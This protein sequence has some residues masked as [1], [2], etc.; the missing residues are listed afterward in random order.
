MQHIA[1]WNG[2][3]WSG[4]AGGVSFLPSPSGDDTPLVLALAEYDDGGGSALY[5]GGDFTAAGGVPAN[6]VAKWNGSSWSAL[7]SG[8]NSTVLS[9]AVYD[10]G[11]GPALYAG[12]RFTTAGGVA[13]SRIAKWD[14]SSW[15]ALGSGTNSDVLALTAHDDGGGP[16]LYAGGHFATAGGAA[17]SAIARW[18]GASWSAVGGGM[19][20]FGWVYSLAE[21]D[22]G[23]G[24]A[25]YAGGGFTTAGGVA[26]NRIAKWDGVS[27]SAL[28]GGVFGDEVNDG[29]YAMATHD[30]GSGPALI[31]AGRFRSAL[32]SGDSYVAKWGCDS[33][34][35]TLSCPSSV[36]VTERFGSPLGEIVNYSVTASDE[37]DPAPG[38]VGVPPSGSLF[39]IGTTLVTC[40]ATDASGN[41]STCQFPVTVSLK[42]R[43]H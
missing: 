17:A 28:D 43:R 22:D 2:S 41:Q 20:S 10:D 25:L 34:P 6:Y 21:H 13:A 3:S 27:W 16:A 36:F 23:S 24:R 38:I 42:I 31:A 1:R 37:V 18:D 12:G 4:L 14:G 5:A 29:V 39:P 11:G 8:V 15:S 7:G 40:T 26:A 35:P 19:N 30:D 33:V 32:D 9:L